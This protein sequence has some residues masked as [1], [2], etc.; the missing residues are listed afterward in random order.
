MP[1]KGFGSRGAQRKAWGVNRRAMRNRSRTKVWAGGSAEEL[2]ALK[3]GAV[4]QT[5]ECD[6]LAVQEVP[7]ITLAAGSIADA[8]S[9]PV[10]PVK[11]EV[12]DA[13]ERLETSR[14]RDGVVCPHCSEHGSYRMKGPSVRKGLHKCRKCRQQF[15]V[16]VGT[17]LH[18]M[19]VSH[20]QLLRA[21][22]LMT[23]ERYGINIH[24]IRKMVGVSYKTAWRLAF[25]LRSVM[26]IAS[27]PHGAASPNYVRKA[28]Y[29]GR[30]AAGRYGYINADS[31]REE[32]LT[33]VWAMIPAWVPQEIKE[34][35]C[36]DLLVSILAG[37][38]DFARAP[39]AMNKYIKE[40]RQFMPDSFK[41]V[42][43]ETMPK[44]EGSDALDFV[45]YE[46]DFSPA[47]LDQIE[48]QEEAQDTG[49]AM[50]RYIE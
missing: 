2:R 46:D 25:M 15:T 43:I 44:R 18:K 39:A 30:A 8:G 33:R 34:D 7:E 22:R 14:W 3:R 20:E 36:Q 6:V 47:L 1:K 11:H 21:V 23:E 19:K 50:W 45:R 29:S 31:Q 37:E 16:T 48:R 9:I 4:A 42:S 24:G 40:A 12:E 10:S 32:T 38:L 41:T 17:I 49:V 13:L 26:R 27:F 5:E 28:D 35:L